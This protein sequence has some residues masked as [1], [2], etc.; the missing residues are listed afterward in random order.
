MEDFPAPMGQASETPQR[1]L[2]E[3]LAELSGL[4]FCLPGSITTRRLRCG[5]PRC[6]CRSDPPRMHGPYT[7]WTRKVGRRTVAQLLSAEQAERY[8]R[9]IEN[10]RR[11]RELVRE[12]EALSVDAAQKAEGWAPD[13]APERG[14]RRR[15]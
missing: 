12:I 14:A 6:R 4:G 5:N 7:Y 1:R 13:P 15:R 3:L 9:W 11:L 10:D 2:G 8:R